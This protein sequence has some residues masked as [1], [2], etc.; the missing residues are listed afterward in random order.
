MGG[1]V[2]RRRIRSG[3][4]T[5]PVRELNCYLCST[6]AAFPDHRAGRLPHRFFRGLVGGF[7]YV[8]ACLL[9]ESPYAILY[10]EGFD[11]FVTSTITPIT[12][13]WSDELPGGAFTRWNTN[14]FPGAPVIDR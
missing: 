8:P 10:I 13:G 1:A 5:G 12:S 2:R 14:T 7:T 9:A 3:K 6:V 11:G 4:Q